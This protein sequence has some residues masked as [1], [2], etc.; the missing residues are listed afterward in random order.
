M[1]AKEIST[2]IVRA[3]LILSGIALSVGLLYQIRILF[4]YIALAFVLALIGKPLVDFLYRKCKIKKIFSICITMLFFIGVFVGFSF[5]FVPL[6]TTQ[7]QNLS[8]LNTAHLQEDFNGLLD[9]IDLYLDAK[10]FSLDKIIEESH[11]KSQFNLDFVPNLLNTLISMLSDIGIGLF[12]VF[13]IAFF[14][15]KDQVV[16]EYQF[17]KLFSKKHE[18]KVLNSI[19]KINNLLSRYFV[20]LCIQIS[21]IYVLCFTV[22][23]IFGVKG[24]ATIAF[25]CAILNI[26]PYIGPL[27]GTIL[28]V[29]FT[30]LTFIGDDF[31]GVTIP[32]ALSVMV[33]FLL[34]QLLDNVVSQPLIFSNSVKSH[35][36]EIFVV[37][38]ASGMFGGIFGMIAAV[39]LYTCLKVIGKEFFPNIRFIQVLTKKL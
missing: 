15:L 18:N 29:V 8:V 3:V 6:F 20:G 13:F 10:G 12:S 17:K 34:V 22:L 23:L 24:A 26:I 11:L 16:L 2:G 7:A 33:G 9:K 19:N 32:K 31:I 21:V 38:L 1:K 37:I 35:P 25:L 30:M 28:A 27:I 14:F 5:M 39:P 4:I 36:L